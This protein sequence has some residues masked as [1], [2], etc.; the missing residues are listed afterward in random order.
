M[1]IYLEKAS[2]FC[3]PCCRVYGAA[4]RLQV[5][6]ISQCKDLFNYIE[7]GILHQLIPI[8][9]ETQDRISKSFL[10]IKPTQEES[11]KHFMTSNAKPSL[12]KVCRDIL[13]YIGEDPGRDGLIKTPKRFSKMF[14]ELTVG[15]NQ[16]AREI[17]NGA[18]FKADKH[19]LVTVRKIEFQSLCEHHILPFYG[20]VHV[21]YVPNEKIIGLSKIPRI[22]KMYSKRLQVQERL[23]G[24]IVDTIEEFLTP[25]GVACVIEA[26]HMCAV[27]RGVKI[28]S[29]SMVSS[30]FKGDLETNQSLKNEFLSLIRM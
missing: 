29:S 27:M 13:E 24:Q 17:I 6:N 5:H 11:Y 3:P 9:I 14:D 23:I 21:G 18:V 2:A 22:V 25:L 19:Q 16:N 28:Q 8:L 30:I 1:L 4:E 10:D 7:Y 26:V 12:E 15:Y 20:Y